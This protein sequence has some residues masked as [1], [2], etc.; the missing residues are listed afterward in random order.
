MEYTKNLPLKLKNMGFKLDFHS[1]WL[2]DD[3]SDLNYECWKKGVLDV[4]VDHQIMK[5]TVD[6]LE[7]T[8]N[9]KCKTI[10]QLNMLDEILN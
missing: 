9:T 2:P 6:I 5:V 7:G 4:T 3:D 10:K 8:D 1:D